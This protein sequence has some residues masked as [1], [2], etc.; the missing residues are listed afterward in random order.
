MKCFACRQ[1]SERVFLPRGF[2]EVHGEKM[3]SFI[4]QHGID[5][6]DEWGTPIVSPGKVPFNYIV[7]DGWKSLMRAITTLDSLLLADPPYLLIPASWGVA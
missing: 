1:Y 6:D 2:V 7:G 5:A 4:Q 3:T